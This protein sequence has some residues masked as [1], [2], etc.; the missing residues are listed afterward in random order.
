MAIKG[1]SL[2]VE[3]GDIV[4]ILGANGAGKSTILKTISGVMDPEKGTIE[5]MDQRIDGM[6]PDKIVR[7]GITQVPEGREIFH[8]LTVK[9]N[10][11]MGAYLRKDRSETQEDLEIVHDYFPVL[12][13]RSSQLGGNMSGGEQQML[14]IGRAIMATPK[15]LLLDEPSLGLAP[16]LVKEIFE[17]IKRV[18]DEQKTTILLVEQNALIALSL[19]RIGYVLELGRIVK[20]DTCKELMENE[21]VK[22]FYLGVKEESIRGSKRWKRKKKWR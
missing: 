13:A 16:F 21:D 8:D 22:E 10:L 4:T 7:M 6:S 3:E 19:A 17:I 18:N 15:L 9:E 5:F 1:V 12:K 14:A 20:E 11:M 2:D